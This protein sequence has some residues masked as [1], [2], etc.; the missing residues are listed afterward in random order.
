MSWIFLDASGLIPME[1]VRDQW[2]PNLDRVMAGLRRAG[3]PDFVTTNWTLY[4][5]LAQVRRTSRELAHH[6][7]ER[8]T[9]EM[10]VVPVRPPIER[11]A[12]DRFLD[13]HSQTASVVDIANVL[14][15][16][17]WGCEAIIS[18][19]DDY[20]PLIMNTGMRLLR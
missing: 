6:L 1:L 15:A 7:Y 18:F 8:V 19:D 13:W 11:A 10:V 17:E 2:R 5:A 12:L 14:V 20:V 9:S 16:Q 3:R 4:E